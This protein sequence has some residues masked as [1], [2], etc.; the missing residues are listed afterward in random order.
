M[1]LFI[2][3]ECYYVTPEASEGQKTSTIFGF[4][5]FISER[6]SRPHGYF[7]HNCY[8][9]SI[10]CL[11]Q[12]VAECARTYDGISAEHMHDVLP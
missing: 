2:G 5:G 1:P 10:T 12:A 11:M 9:P 3:D 6:N 8:A 7:Y 4:D